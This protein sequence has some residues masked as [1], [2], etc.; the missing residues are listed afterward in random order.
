MS[1]YLYS[2]KFMS[3]I[4]FKSVTFCVTSDPPPSIL[5]PVNASGI[6]GGA[7][8]MACSAYSTVDFNIT[9]FRASDRIDLSTLSRAT[10]F[11]NGSVILRQVYLSLCQ[12]GSLTHSFIFEERPDRYCTIYNG[13]SRISEK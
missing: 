4:S 2:P 12:K 11:S 8:L 5:P 6:P 1:Y 10:V 7:V 3:E 13:A 9:W